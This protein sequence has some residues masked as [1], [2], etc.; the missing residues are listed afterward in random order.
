MRG[1]TVTLMLLA[2]ATLCS[3]AAVAPAQGRG[4]RATVTSTHF[5]RYLRERQATLVQT[6]RVVGELIDEQGRAAFVIAHAYEPGR[7]VGHEAEAFALQ[8]DLRTPSDA[9]QVSSGCLDPYEA[10]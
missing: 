7:A 8:V 2:A 4:G 9:E 6:R 3:F 5:E 10:E 1:R